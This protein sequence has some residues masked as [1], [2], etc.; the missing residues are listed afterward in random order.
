MTSATQKVER[1]TSDL[2][3]ERSRPSGGSGEGDAESLPYQEA[4]R[5]EAVAKSTEELV[6]QAE[7]LRQSLDALRKTA[8]ATG[9]NDSA[10]QR[11]LAEIRDELERAISPELKEKLVSL[12]RALA[13]L[14]AERTKEALERLAE[15]QKEM[16]EAL[17][18][19]RELFRRAAL[20]GDIANLI[21]ESKQ[22]A[23]EQKQWNQQVG[24]LDSARAALVE[25]QLAGRTDTLAAALRQVAKNAATEGKQGEMGEL[26]Q[27]AANASGQMQQAAR[28]AQRGDR[29]QA[30]RHG[31]EASRSLDPLSDQLQRRRQE[32]QRNWRK[33]VVQAIDQAL[34]ETSRLAEQQLQVHQQLQAQTEPSA[35]TRAEQAAIEEGVRKVVEQVRQVAGK[36]ALVPAQ[37]GA[38]LGAAQIRMQK[39]R[40]AISSAVPNSREAIEQAGEAVD[41]LNVAAHQLLQT[42]N[43]VSGAQSGSGLAEALEQLAQLAQQQGGLGQQGAGL[44]PL[45]GSAA[46]QEH[47]R[48]LAAQQRGLAQQLEKLRAEGS[49]AGAGDMADEAQELARRLESGRIDPQVVQRQER[50][51][52]RMLDAGRTLRGREEDEKKERQS[53]TATDDSVHLP[54]AL[55][56]RLEDENQRLRV[57]T[58]E[59]LQRLSPEERR[60]VVDYFR[61]VSELPSR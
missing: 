3:Q 20:E 48:K 51:F 25:R 16:R 15:A 40:D 11:Q 13:A 39:T 42:R 9:V 37:I 5:A 1:Q 52:R 43:N 27:Q 10:W 30:R 8:E 19:S 45:G 56:A 14:D 58:W 35:S 6:R 33:Q 44:L 23:R 17:E 26:A 60:L 32:M 49:I 41:A 7:T 31:E 50:L 2:A 12:Q 34:A 28:S 54:P 47:I 4:Q 53:A 18:R 59:E 61:R 38:A 36:N 29:T 46:V 57:P 24:S 55:R 22:L 21:E